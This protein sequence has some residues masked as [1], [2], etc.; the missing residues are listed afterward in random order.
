M[1]R[2]KIVYGLTEIELKLDYIP[3]TR[4]AGDL[5]D[6]YERAYSDLHQALSFIK[7]YDVG[8]GVFSSIYM[9]HLRITISEK[10]NCGG[11]T[12]LFNFKDIEDKTTRELLAI[13]FQIIVSHK[14]KD[15]LNKELMLFFELN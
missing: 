7:A 15:G 10:P 14:E 4:T 2:A 6:V 9:T 1:K 13:V 3:D 8:I 5:L 11:N 12:L